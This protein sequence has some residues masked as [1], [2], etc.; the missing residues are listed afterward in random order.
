MKNLSLF[1][2]KKKEIRYKKTIKILCMDNT[3]LSRNVG[4]SPL[5]VCSSFQKHLG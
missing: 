3:G 1:K 2:K 5:E 4:S